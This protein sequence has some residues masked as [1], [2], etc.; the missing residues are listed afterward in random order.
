MAGRNVGGPWHSGRVE[1]R[2]RDASDLM[3][4]AGAAGR[5]SASSA[6]QRATAIPTLDAFATIWA[7]GS[8]QGWD[9]VQGA[10]TD[11]EGYENR[12]PA[13]S[14][15][16]RGLGRGLGCERQSCAS[17]WMP[18]TRELLQEV[19]EVDL[20]RAGS[21]SVHASDRQRCHVCRLTH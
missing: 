14:I 9:L 18:R 6:H 3:I 15:R 4:A 7:G 8:M 21:V 2:G 5:K 20:R 1:Q 16:S 11:N 12:G 17:A 19:E 13:S 10:A